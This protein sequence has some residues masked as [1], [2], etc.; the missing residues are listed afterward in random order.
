MLTDRVSNPGALTYE[1]G[2]LQI[3]LRGLALAEGNIFC[4]FLF[5]SFHDVAL[6]KLGKPLKERIY[7]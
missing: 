5:D 6:P 1:S 2:A 4:D 7:S 3:A